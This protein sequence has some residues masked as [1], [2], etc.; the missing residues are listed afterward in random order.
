MGS[1]SSMPRTLLLVPPGEALRGGPPPGGRSAHRV[2]A[3]IPRPRRIPWDAR[4][5]ATKSADSARTRGESVHGAG[6]NG[7]AQENRPPPALGESSVHV[8]G[9]GRARSERPGHPG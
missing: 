4:R 1:A 7:G 3:I 5:F 9:G 2:S 6:V 8:D